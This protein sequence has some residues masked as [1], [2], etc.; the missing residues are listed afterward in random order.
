[1]EKSDAYMK[2]FKLQENGHNI[3]KYIELL[4]KSDEVPAEVLNYLE[5]FTNKVTSTKYLS[6]LKTKKFY[7][8][9]MESDNIY[10]QAKGLSSFVTHT[11]IELSNH[12]EV[13]LAISESVDIKLINDSLTNFMNSGKADY[14]SESIKYVK[15]VLQRSDNQ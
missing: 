15:S 5:S 10:E 7:K 11:L 6:E 13:R 12:P 8:T 14:I 9:I 1:M 4:A 2:L 3:S